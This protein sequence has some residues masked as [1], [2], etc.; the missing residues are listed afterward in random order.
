M[1]DIA[2]GNGRTI[3]TNILRGTILIDRIRNLD[4]ATQGRPK[5]SDWNIW[6]KVLKL[7]LTDGQNQLCNPVGRWV[8][9]V[10][11][12]YANEWQWFCDE[13]GEELY[14]AVDGQWRQ[15][16]LVRVRHRTRNRVQHFKTYQ[17]VE[18]PDN[19]ASL[20]R[21]SVSITGTTV[22]SEGYTTVLD[23]EPEVE[24]DHP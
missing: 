13:A 19:A 2:S 8:E 6:R 3:D 18:V 16:N 11:D 23:K 5:V 24:V 17:I 1:A 7:A 14:K 12:L 20:F 21:T 10:E 4:F 9:N 22:V 15:Y